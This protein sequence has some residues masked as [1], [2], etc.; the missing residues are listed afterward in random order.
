MP[1]KFVRTTFSNVAYAPL[2]PTTN[3]RATVTFANVSGITIRLAG[4]A[5]AAPAIG[6][7]VYSQIAS[8]SGAVYSIECNPARTYMACAA[9]GGTLEMSIQY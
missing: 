3:G 6:T 2:D 7:T 4:E 1:T 5:D 8:N 9:G